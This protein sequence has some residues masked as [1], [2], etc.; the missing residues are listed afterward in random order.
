[1]LRFRRGDADGPSRDRWRGSHTRQ[2][3]LMS[4]S[5][6][7][8]AIGA[9]AVPSPT[10]TD[11]AEHR[12]DVAALLVAAFGPPPRA[13]ARDRIQLGRPDPNPYRIA[14][15]PRRACACPACGADDMPP[16]SPRGA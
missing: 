8:D 11:T 4:R 16:P 13:R 10:R 7:G 15:R 3:D 6:R 2:A 12:T 5:M 9:D 1:M 14:D